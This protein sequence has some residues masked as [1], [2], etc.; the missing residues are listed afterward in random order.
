M[1]KD[2]NHYV[3]LLLVLGI[4]LI[5]P[6]LISKAE[7]ITNTTENSEIT[8][9]QSSEVN[10][11]ENSMS[12][13]DQVE[14]LLF[15][16][17]IS[18][19]SNDVIDGRGK[20]HKHKQ[21]LMKKKKMIMMMAVAFIG[22][23]IHAFIK[24]IKAVIKLKLLVAVAIIIKFHLFLLFF[25]A[26]KHFFHEQVGNI[27]GKHNFHEHEYEHH[28]HHPFDFFG[29]H[30]HFKNKHGLLGP[31][32][33]LFGSSFHKEDD[34]GAD[35]FGLS[36]EFGG[37]G[38]DDHEDLFKREANR[39]KPGHYDGDYSAHRP[40][41][42][43]HPHY[44]Q[45]RVAKQAPLKR[46][47]QVAENLTP[48]EFIVSTYHMP[49]KPDSEVYSPFTRGLIDTD[50]GM[51]HYLSQPHNNVQSNTHYAQHI[52]SISPS[53]EVIYS[54]QATPSSHDNKV[55]KDIQEV[56]G[57]VLETLNNIFP[58]LDG[59]DKHKTINEKQT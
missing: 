36:N 26:K 29:K 19:A 21:H 48:P 32:L 28:S 23:V 12:L 55:L 10:T 2:N 56:S 34:H 13:R 50:P 59:V 49:P 24:G 30:D 39:Y 53:D 11:S 46:P 22:G 35:L 18:E 33:K 47:S 4:F 58:K 45:T 16:W 52:D 41:Y 14:N 8:T 43:Y 25:K 17:D 37:H 6:G 7:A 31:L 51:I 57:S 40:V 20:K 54:P 3:A 44:T 38:H 9:L 42:N 1:W 15:N 27:F 5:T